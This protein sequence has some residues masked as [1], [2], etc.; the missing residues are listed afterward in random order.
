LSPKGLS[1]L[2]GDDTKLPAALPIPQGQIPNPS[3]DALAQK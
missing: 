3:K 1:R 2:N